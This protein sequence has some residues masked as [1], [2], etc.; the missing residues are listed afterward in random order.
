MTGLLADYVTVEC[1]CGALLL[2]PSRM[3]TGLDAAL[4]WSC[5]AA[6]NDADA[7]AQAGQVK[8]GTDKAT[9]KGGD[10]RNGRG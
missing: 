1:L 3:A 5:T 8:R 10:G 7:R 2:V 4:C 6:R 9:N